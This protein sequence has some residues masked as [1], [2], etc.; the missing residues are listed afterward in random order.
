[1]WKQ[2]WDHYIPKESLTIF[3]IEFKYR[4][5]LKVEIGIFIIGLISLTGIAAAM[6]SDLNNVAKGEKFCSIKKSF[7]DYSG[8]GIDCSPDFFFC[9]VQNK[10]CASGVSCGEWDTSKTTNA[11]L[12]LFLLTPL[13]FAIKFMESMFY[14]TAF[15][16]VLQPST[17]REKWKVYGYAF[18][19]SLLNWK[20]DL[21]AGEYFIKKPTN[22]QM[23]IVLPFAYVFSIAM[24]V[25]TVYI[26]FLEIA[27]CISVCG[28]GEFAQPH[29]PMSAYI[30]MVSVGFSSTKDLFNFFTSLKCRCVTLHACYCSSICSNQC[31]EKVTIVEGKKPSLST[32]S[33]SS[34]QLSV[35]LNN[36]STSTTARTKSIS[37]VLLHEDQLAGVGIDH[38]EGMK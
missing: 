31:C 9:E 37:K 16:D 23:Y 22:Q 2:I 28:D 6:Y 20:L 5:I 21:V 34:K 25:A 18:L 4:T 17:R 12:S 26:Y 11:R 7:N 19:G 27:Y 29:P 8:C 13:F 14:H 1:M 36:T 38:E 15:T 24:Y 33:S 35:S 30:T 3:G 10:T 32:S